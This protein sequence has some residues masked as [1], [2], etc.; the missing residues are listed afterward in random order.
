MN[1]SSSQILYR[2]DS[3][4]FFGGVGVGGED[5]DGMPLEHIYNTKDHK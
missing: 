2:R 1:T 4:L 5:D 3:E